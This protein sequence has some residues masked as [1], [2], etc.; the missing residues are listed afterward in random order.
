[1]GIRPVSEK[2]AEILF[3]RSLLQAFK[4]G[5]VQLFAPTSHEECE[6]GYDA[7]VV[8]F[9]PIREL[10][11]QF[12]SPTYTNNRFT[13]K[14]TRH[15]H[16]RLLKYPCQS[17]YYVAPMFASLSELNEAQ[18]SMKT[19]ADFLKHFVCIEVSALEHDIDFFQYI[20]PANHQKSPLVKYKS[21]RD[22]IGRIARHEIS[23][24]GWLRGS[25]LLANFRK[26]SIGAYWDL[27]V[28]GNQLVDCKEQTE[29]TK[30]QGNDFSLH[31]RIPDFQE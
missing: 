30:S 7:K 17:A 27:G 23:G 1:M 3:N 21:A 22:G 31:I 16:L 19:A 28:S 18:A 13:I 8:G 24:D 14:T 29:I 11:L 15:Q 20:K 6:K 26:K 4:L 10:Y 25:T 12:K 9:T 2:T 5:K